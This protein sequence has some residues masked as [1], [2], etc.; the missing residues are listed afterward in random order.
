MASRDL[1]VYLSSTHDQCPLTQSRNYPPLSKISSPLQSRTAQSTLRLSQRLMSGLKGSRAVKSDRLDFSRCYF[2]VVWD[3][4]IT[5]RVLLGLQ[6]L[7]AQLTPRTY[8]VDNV[9][10]PADAAVYG[11]LHPTIVRP[12]ETWFSSKLTSI[13]P[14]AVSMAASSILLSPRPDALLRSHTKP[15]CRPRIRR[16]AFARLLPC[17]V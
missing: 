9:L 8:I 11:A 5:D 17:D 14:G 1:R 15:S 6:G 13:L 7:D 3:L 2:I 4:V 10:T 12:K 16:K